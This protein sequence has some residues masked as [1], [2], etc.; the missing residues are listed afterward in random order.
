MHA[1]RA[2]LGA[3]PSLLTSYGLTLRTNERRLG[4]CGRWPRTM[5]FGYLGYI[6]AIFGCGGIFLVVTMSALVLY[7]LGRR[8][9][10]AGQEPKV[11]V[12]TLIS[13]E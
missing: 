3:R 4:E 2:S 5:T 9:R 1:P 13:K 11:V 7:A 10:K 12:E 8:G 6:W